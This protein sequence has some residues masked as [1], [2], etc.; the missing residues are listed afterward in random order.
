MIKIQNGEIISHIS[1]KN[2]IIN[3]ILVI[4]IV[5]RK[6]LVDQINPD[7]I[8]TYLK[9]IIAPIESQINKTFDVNEGYWKLMYL[10]KNGIGELELYLYKYSKNEIEDK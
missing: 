7:G 2:E 9:T 3:L 4:R 1:Q 10:S 6:V 5:E 8:E